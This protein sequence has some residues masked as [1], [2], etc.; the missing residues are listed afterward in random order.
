MVRRRALRASCRHARPHRGRDRDRPGEAGRRGYESG[1]AP[2]STRALPSELPFA[3]T[4]PRHR[5]AAAASSAASAQT[6]LSW[7]MHSAAAS[8]ESVPARRAGFAGVLTCH[9]S[10]PW[11]IVGVPIGQE[12]SPIGRGSMARGRAP[13]AAGRRARSCALSSRR[14]GAPAPEDRRRVRCRVPASPSS[15]RDT[16]PAAAAAPAVRCRSRCPAG[17]IQARASLP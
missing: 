4:F 14:T 2:A 1:S 6:S 7:R 5:P 12:K 10:L 8:Q 17:S 15:C 3:P 9:A 11:P 16:E 13:R